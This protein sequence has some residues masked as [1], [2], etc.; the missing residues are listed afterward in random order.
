VVGSGWCQTQSAT[1][2]SYTCP[3]STTHYPPLTTHLNSME[4]DWYN[5]AE[6][7]Q[8]KLAQLRDSL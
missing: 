4:T 7:V 2:P 5:R 3:L 6:A 1:T 8:Q